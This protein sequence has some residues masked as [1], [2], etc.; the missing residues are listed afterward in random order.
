VRAPRAML[1]GV[2]GQLVMLPAIALGLAL[3]LPLGEATAIGLMLV[4]ACPGG[5][6][7]NMFAS[8]ARGDV[9]L[10]ISLTAISGIAAPVTVPLVLGIGFGVIAGIDAPIRVSVQQMVITLVA[11]TALPVLLG[12]ALHTWR[13]DLARRVR[14]PLLGSATALMILLLI[15]LFVNTARM[16][17]DVL[18]MFA[19]SSL[20]VALL[21]GC[22]AG[23]ACVASRLFS[24][25]RADERTL[26]LEVGVQNINLAL[27]VAIQFLDDFRYLG[28]SL[29]Y[30]PFMFLLGGAIVRWG[31]HHAD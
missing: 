30:I 1:L 9:A 27:L 11:T 4:A 17:P 3:A 8:Y 19:R 22:C 6:T 21:I 26:I 13:A 15:G 28:P 25:G 14:G 24:L 20:A 23:A 7:S 18:G 10:S 5:T 29:V 12:L 16:Q 2:I 31:R